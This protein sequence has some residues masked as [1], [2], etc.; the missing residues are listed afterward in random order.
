MSP[1]LFLSPQRSVWWTVVPT[2]HASVVCVSARKAGQDQNVSRE[3]VTHA[4]STM[5]SAGRASVTATRAGRVNTA[6]SVSHCDTY[7]AAHLRTLDRRVWTTEEISLWADLKGQLW[8]VSVSIFQSK[9]IT[10]HFHHCLTPSNKCFY[11]THW[12]E[13]LTDIFSFLKWTGVS[14]SSVPR[15]R[16]ITYCQSDLFFSLC[17]PL[18]PEQIIN[19]H[20]IIYHSESSQWTC[21]L[22][23]IFCYYF[24]RT[25]T[26]STE[27]LFSSANILVIL[28][29]C[30]LL[31][32]TSAASIFFW[33]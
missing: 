15:D 33:W 28:L 31:Q 6:P 30:N 4:A 2:D 8:S 3:T 26:W 13:V 18:W 10:T 7:I 25:Y 14:Y 16:W 23:L 32:P 20:H 24:Y 9:L 5:E 12:W 22:F 1:W 17:L 29:F 19:T 21:L 11:M 27:Y